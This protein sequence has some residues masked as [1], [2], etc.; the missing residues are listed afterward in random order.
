MLNTR[1]NRIYY[2]LASVLVV[3]L[4][5][6]VELNIYMNPMVNTIDHVPSMVDGLY[7]TEK[8]DFLQVNNIRENGMFRWSRPTVLFKFWPAPA[9]SR[10]FTITYISATSDIRI[11]TDQ[12]HIGI[13]P[14]TPVTRIA[15]YLRRQAH[16]LKCTYKQ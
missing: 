10:L 8:S 13:L 6:L 9:T 5:I 11:L 2:L 3:V 7:A 1:P 14:T 16:P 4:S 15:T 12:L